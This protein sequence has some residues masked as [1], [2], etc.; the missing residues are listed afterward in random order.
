MQSKSWGNVQADLFCWQLCEHTEAEGKKKKTNLGTVDTTREKNPINQRA[1]WFGRN[2]TSREMAY[3]ESRASLYYRELII[4]WKYVKERGVTG[5][6]A[7]QKTWS[8]T[9]W[10]CPEGYFNP[11]NCWTWKIHWNEKQSSDCNLCVNHKLESCEI[12]FGPFTLLVLEHFPRSKSADTLNTGCMKS[13][14][15]A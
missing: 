10:H 3:R 14:M 5:L 15:G 12:M 13:L 2:F 7:L 11:V 8:L 6:F 1:L 4:V 9:K